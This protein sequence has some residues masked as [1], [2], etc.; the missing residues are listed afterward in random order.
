MRTPRTFDDLQRAVARHYDGLSGR[1][2]QVAE[3]AV[4]HPNDMALETVAGVARRAGVQPSAIVRFANFLGYA[5]FS[6]MQRVF[7][8]RLV[9]RSPSYRERIAAL[10]AGRDQGGPDTTPA[11][12][13]AQ[14]VG[15]GVAALE[16]LEENIAGD[17]LERALGVLVQAQEIFVLAQGR[18][19]PVA[20]YLN[21]A[22]SRL[23]Q[24]C[25]LLAGVGGTAR[26]EARA[27][28]RDDVLLAVSFR[29]YSPEVVAIVEEC[30]AR[31]VKIVAITDSALSPLARETEIAFVVPQDETLPF[32]SLVA[33]MCLAQ[34]LVVAYGHHLAS[35]RN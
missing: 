12:V 34:S 18:A 35:R 14:F 19:F 22:F 3:F 9:A 4:Q 2:R 33:P 11:A 5:G 25:R 21:Y 7:R 23:D 13:L 17:D 24:R 29:D 10:R 8:H 20:F 6:E 26:V 27:A 30:R 32:R 31:A 16:H 15:D 28:G 1:L